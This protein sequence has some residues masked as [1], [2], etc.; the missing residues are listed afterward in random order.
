MSRFFITRREFESKMA[1]ANLY[2]SKR[3]RH[4]EQLL[5]MSREGA[6]QLQ[7]VSN[8]VVGS[9]IVSAGRES[10]EG[11]WQIYVK[12]NDADAE[13]TVVRSGNKDTDLIYAARKKEGL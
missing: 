9:L 2:W 12:R 10:A 8:Q 11:E 4:L 1:D 5:R 7:D 13:Y 6:K 3:V